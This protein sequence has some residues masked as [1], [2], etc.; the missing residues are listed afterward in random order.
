MAGVTTARIRSMPHPQVLDMEV[1]IKEY[2]LILA[3]PVAS[4][5]GGRFL[6]SKYSPKLAEL[7]EWFKELVLK[8]SV[9]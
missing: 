1:L 4:R 9:R 7:S 6:R 5:F 2:L 3:L 8:T